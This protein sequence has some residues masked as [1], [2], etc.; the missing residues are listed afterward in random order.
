M[1]R[2]YKVIWNTSRNTWMAAGE[3]AKAQGK[4]K[5]AISST[6]SPSAPRIGTLLLAAGLSVP[7]LP[8]LAEELPGSGT[9]SAGSGSISSDGTD[10]MVTQSS[11]RMS[12]N[13]LSFSIGEGNSV[14]FDQPSTSSIALNRVTG[15]DVSTIQGALNANGRVFLINPNG[16]LFNPTAQVNVGG[17]VASTLEL[18]DEDFLAG[19]HTFEG[20]S[21]AAITNEGTIR[22]AQ[23]GAVALVAARIVNEGAIE[24]PGG[25]VALGS[26][27]RVTLDLGGP[28]K[29]QVEKGALDGLIEQ[30]GAIRA[31]GGQVYL[32]AKAADGLASS[33]I[34]HTG[35]TE[36]RTLASGENGEIVLLGDMDNGEVN[37]AGT[38]DA[39]AP[40]G[41]DG[42]FI[43]TSAAKV[44]VADGTAITT[45]AADG[46]TG[47]WLID[48]KDYTIAAS[49]GDI[50]GATL[51]SQLGSSGVMI[52]S[53]NGAADG[54]GDI[55]VNDTVSW[56]A[57]ALVLRADRNIEINAEM[58]ASD[59]AGLALEYNRA[60][61][62]GDYFVNAP[63]NLAS[64]GNFSTKD[65][66]ADSVQYIIITDLGEQ[67]S[68]EADLQG[69][70]N[71]PS[72]NYVLGADIDAGDTAGW[73]AGAGFEPVGTGTAGNAFTGR[74]DGLGHTISDLTINRPDTNQV[75]LFG[76]TRGA[77]LRN[78]GL[79]GGSVTG[80]AFDVG[81]L[82]GVNG[83]SSSISNA[84]TTGRVTGDANVG[85]LVG[86]NNGS[87]I[88]NAYTT[89]S[90]MGNV[91]FVGGLVGLNDD[92]S[93]IN[94]YATGNVTGAFGVGG[95]V[96]WNNASTISNAYV[97]G[98][99]T[100]D[101]DVGGLMG[102][103]GPGSTVTDS[104][105]N[106]DTSNQSFGIGSDP[107]N[108]TVTG[109]T[110]AQ[111][112]NAASFDGF[113]FTT[114]WSIKEGQTSP[115]IASHTRHSVLL[116][117]S[118]AYLSVKTL[119]ELQAMNSDLS[120][121]YVLF[122]DIDAGDTAGWNAGA[123]FEPVGTGTSGS[124]FTGRFDGLGHNIGDLT[125]N[126]DSTTGVGLFGFT[127]GAT[128][129][130]VGLVGGS[131][132]GQTN[133]G[134]LVGRSSSSTISN[135]YATGSVTGRFYVGGL[136]GMNFQS[137]ISNAYATGSVSSLFLGAGGLVGWN[138]S[139]A[140]SNAYATNSVKGND[141]VGGLVGENEDH[142]T[143]SNAYATGSVTGD[144]SVGGLIGDNDFSSLVSNSYWN[145][146][147]SGQ[148]A[149][150]G[151]DDNNQTVTGL[152]TADMLNA[153][154]FGG[155]DFA[156]SWSIKE[157]QTSP[158]ITAN[159]RHSVLL[160]DGAAYLSVK[161][162]DELQA[163]N[164]DLSGNY[165][166]FNDIDAGDT[167]SW[168][169]GQGFAPV[170]TASFI[171]ENPFTGRF[172]GLGHTISDLTIAAS[173]DIGVGLFGATDGA[174]LRNVGLVGGNVTGNGWVGSLV[175]WN[176][177]STISNAYATGSVTG[178]TDVGG[179]VGLNDGST[180]S[181]AYATGWVAGT[182]FD[183]DT[184]GRV[185]GLVGQNTNASEIRDA[186]ATGTVEGAGE[187]G[188]LVGLND[189]STISGAYAT[190]TLRGLRDL[191]GLVGR[192]IS[193]GISNAY[194]TGSVGVE[195]VSINVGGLVGVNDGST[196]SNAY[197]T[198]SVK[199][200]EV[201]GGLVG[202]NVD[203]TV[204]NSY[205]NTETSEHASGIGTDNNGQTV[206][207]LT[208]AD[209][210]NAANFGGFDFAAT[211]SIKEGQTSPYITSH[212]RHSVLLS[213]GAAYLSV[214]T[215]DELQAMNSDLAGNYVLFNDIEAGETASWNAGEGFDPVGT[216]DAFNEFTGRFDGLDHTIS[217][218]TIDRPDT[219]SVG[220]F[221]AINGAILRNIG[222]VGGSVTG[223]GRVGG[224]VGQ[225]S[226][227][228]S[229]SN[230]YTTGNVSGRRD[231]GGLVGR[232]FESDISN[233]YTTGSVT[234]TGT[235]LETG[236]SIGGLVGSNKSSTISDAYA[237]G[238]VSGNSIHVGGLVGEND[239]ST[240]DNAYATGSVSGLSQVGGL[241]GL[242]YYSND[243]ST[244]SNAYAT[245]SVTAEDVDNLFANSRA[246]GLVGENRGS[247]IIN[248][249]A[250]GNVTGNLRSVG[251]L[252]GLNTG[253]S[254]ISN[255]YATGSVAG[256]SN[257]GGLVGSNDSST[258]A[259]SYW[260]A[261][262][263][264]QSSG[265]GS[266]NNGQPT[267][268]LSTAEMLNAGN[269]GFDFDNTWSI[270]EGQTSPYITSHTRHSV[271]LSDGAA[272]LSVKTL[273][274]L[275]AMNSDLAG[276]YVLF[277]DID[278]GDTAS[279]N[280]E[281]GFDPVGNDGN[282]FTGRF[283]GLGHTVSDLTIDR[284]DTD[285]VGLF[286]Y[287]SGA[288]LR[289]VGLV[290]GSVTGKDFVGGLAGRNGR[291]SSISNAYTTGSVVGSG[292]YVGGLAGINSN[293]T[294]SNAYATGSVRGGG[295][296]I[297]GLAGGNVVSTISNAY[298]S[299]SVTGDS[300]VGGL[301]GRNDQ[302]AISNAYANGSVSGNTKVGGL[303]G[304]RSLILTSVRDSYWNTE[305]SGQGSSA[306]GT[307]LTTA[308]MQNPF[309]FIDAGWDFETVWG[310]SS[311]SDTPENSGYMMLREVGVSSDALYDDYVKLSGNTSKTYGDA[312]PALAGIT[313]DGLGTD[314]VSL[315]WDS[316][317]TNT[318]DAG[319]YAY[320]GAGVLDVT[321]VSANGVY[322]DYGA[323]NLTIDKAALTVTAND[324]GKTYDGQAFNGGNGVTYAGF[325]ANEDESVLGGSLSFGGTAQNAV[326]AG[327]Y[328]LI[329]AGL[330]SDNYVIDYANGT[331]TVN[332]ATIANITGI[333]AE[334]KTYDGTTDATLDASG[335]GFTG[336][337][338][339]DTLTVATATGAFADKNAGS[340]KTVN[341]SGLTL[342]GD[343]AGNY[344]LDS[345]T[346]TTTADIDKATIA[347]IT[348]ITAGDKI[349]DGTTDATLVA[350]RVG[351]DGM[352]SG[353]TLIIDVDA[354]T[355]TFADKN[356]GSG[357]TVNITGL[358]LGGDDAG[359][360]TLAGDTT[361]TADI[362]KA[363]IANITGITAEDK[364]YDGTT[365]ATLDA[366][367]A[368]FT[369]II[370]GDTLT[371]ATA[372]GAFADKNV[373]SGKTVT[374]G[375]LTLG[376]DDAGNYTLADD[377]STTAADI[378]RAAL[379][380]TANDAD[381]SYDG[382]AFTGGNGVSY[383]GFVAGED[384]RVLGGGLSFGG[385]AQGAVDAG[386][387]TL[388]ASGF[389][390]DNYDIAYNNGT[391]TV[392]SSVSAPADAIIKQT[393]EFASS[394]VLP[395][396]VRKIFV[397]GT[398][399]RVWG[400][401][402]DDGEED[403]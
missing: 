318:T 322:V 382:Q 228:S 183:P 191:G 171:G 107:D 388:T 47:T 56:S 226:F 368:G 33:V 257:V 99:V 303:V 39:S 240:I 362:N 105:W 250:T 207:G 342:G 55:F 355:G 293:S 91:E 41:G 309:T 392:S 310:K 195:S 273:D 66:S 163:M 327:S 246:G 69:M 193:S 116:S 230:V 294:I 315:E 206:T 236:S 172:D 34:N 28:V 210:L 198:G 131:V 125:I 178:A 61:G 265:I 129:R 297:G 291:S 386:T 302:A 336:I 367:G 118:E 216:A 287:T 220:L 177:S 378:D 325:V 312:N 110:T 140:I 384:E 120:G 155:F 290:G 358:I 45:L 19:H 379:S 298:A 308:E 213:D 255:T 85:G 38:L 239:D 64:S 93:I 376:G 299:G 238:S 40:D 92:S 271:L 189:S 296:N 3:L 153:A 115:Y 232:N 390:S 123:G 43:E 380:I 305:T 403:Q 72:F 363:T 174:T 2:T 348:G 319:T 57:N 235:G 320:S 292:D 395:H 154:N 44:R 288:T 51:S 31:G 50:T 67:G 81:G 200:V 75:G 159:A 281:T 306:G 83:N 278:A 398:G 192:S 196:I 16:V 307:G 217:D 393:L 94:A 49:G 370:S 134:A 248:A 313:L 280:G 284:P 133:V 186:Y 377:A 361:T 394:A 63:V 311:N 18:S 266:D 347:N 283:D 391:L 282:A 96:G 12:V 233:S 254:T 166:L 397:D 1:N 29:L 121:N 103:N 279:W 42:G 244:I 187:I 269:F 124:E 151:A 95:L 323:G 270:K 27:S 337:V 365:D 5:S 261:Q 173:D 180:I 211:W 89:G 208:T 304:D 84:Y 128:L 162:L 359:N 53:V 194:A 256:S 205:W 101:N 252:V 100:G 77:T 201:V 164:S 324:A 267:T 32:T 214:K 176:L 179:L 316:A 48:P 209:M 330:S 231:T 354:A 65:G 161:T 366:S 285:Y 353:D 11:E 253:S 168:N 148:S 350:S 372:T 399:I 37:V 202:E 13:W 371:V 160:S 127:S 7:A 402:F 338:S 6:S 74:F 219:D 344:R 156:A 181:N 360:Y 204:T 165:V 275:Q 381:K 329:A 52:E 356:A 136:V 59:S 258:I 349:Y 242:N 62:G 8:A 169:A 351:F 90:V 152:T 237:T 60:G 340:G 147:T 76:V 224:L 346:A 333:T 114:T 144:T 385:T 97:T 10:M 259:N 35:V 212:T 343:D 317:I 243:S 314:N 328:T 274:E 25:T 245:G 143:I 24:A 263:S 389:T 78:V 139:S 221:G 182:G 170:G 369:G 225:S 141:F 218:L 157:G 15:S 87:S 400:S 241:V 20:D 145:T 111:M 334:H 122:N 68:T 80:G 262:T 88:S 339:G 130:N 260:N 345:D 146:E 58:N 197:A 300:G 70:S 158:Y 86:S 286:G 332:Q 264:S 251:G 215:L 4:S 301:V 82:V 26:G 137:S 276:N 135:A 132:T 112:L 374:I 54:N 375:G 175:G 190:G 108:Q 21:T 14:T 396:D 184:S 98:S 71:N 23:G 36:A 222:L 331:L 223:N 109:L 22:A 272:Y 341:I 73:N 9:I 364:T 335:A 277:N 167:A 138:K 229:I 321:T 387:Y 234:G 17:L 227:S 113:D 247:G 142:S 401:E 357:K 106:T 352:V 249:Y 203:S 188:G 268:G 30:G 295:K 126:R 326:N 117:D 102:R 79:V 150:I 149:G 119:D 289:N 104:Y 185:G 46:A 373:G 383:A 199:G